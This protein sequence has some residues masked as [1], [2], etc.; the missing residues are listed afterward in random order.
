MQP[1]AN[2]VQ[3]PV[4]GAC[5][6]CGTQLA[7][8]FLACPACGQLVYAA[9]LRTIASDAEAAVGRGDPVGALGLWREALDLLPP[10]SRQRE[11]VAQKVDALSE[12]VRTGAIKAVPNAAQP[13][14]LASGNKLKA[15][16]AG[17]GAVG[18]LLWKL[19]F[20]VVFVA[21]KGKLLLLG[22]T[23]SSTLFSMLLSLGVY[24]TV[25]GW[26]FALGL[27]L[28]IYVHEMGHVIALNRYGF[29]ATAP[30][31]IPGL[32]ALIR[33]KQHPANPHEDAAIGL[34]GP[35]YGLGAAA[36]SYGLWY[37]TGHPMLAAIAQ[38]GAWINLFNL[39]PIVPLDGGRA[40][41]ALSRKQRWLAAL[42]LATAWFLTSESLLA[43]LLIVAIFRAVGGNGN[44]KGDVKAT[45]IYAGLVLILAAMC[46]IPVPMP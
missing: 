33:L 37:A 10:G 24:W 18:L 15:A 14:P 5:V 6:Q 46:L 28:S 1:G 23:K 4:L 13:A 17:L 41:N 31:F 7:P 8:T 44:E 43:L 12:G 20:I 39:L 25:W 40:F 2:S 36:F 16:A 11:I 45:V 35:I 26:K 29:K 27:V 38:V 22:L 30:T 19:K 32:G 34:A 21:T 3:S 42:S 9:R